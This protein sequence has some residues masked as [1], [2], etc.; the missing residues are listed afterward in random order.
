M[1]ERDEYPAGTPC[2]VD[3]SQPDPEAA[4]QFYG[5]LFGWEFED[6]MPAGAPGHYFAASLDG[7]AVAA[8]GSLPEGAPPTPFWST[9]IWVD[10][11]HETAA[12]VRAAGGKVL[13]EPFD[14]GD[15]GRMAV[16]ADRSG[17]VYCVWQAGQ[18]RG[19]QVVNEPGSWNWS[20]LYTRDPEGALA[21]YGEVFGWVGRRV[22]FGEGMEATMWC[23]PGYADHL[24]RVDPGIRERHAASG[25]PE[26]FSDAIGWLIEM[27]SDQF[28]DDVR[29]H[30]RVTF[31]V[32]DA[33]AI[34]TH[35]AELG[36]AILAPPFDAGPTRM[37]GLSD[38]Q[39][40]MFWVSHYAS[41]E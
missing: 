24:E 30:W 36:G 23:L 31:A 20:D 22:E 4:T 15:A 10:D 8:V 12:K 13:D 5:P 1:I 3:T 40:A 27:S 14:I 32:D 25:A 17:A 28:P 16:F 19:A 34:A 41:G 37:A 6:R 18:H 33:D 35:A 39:G 21:F 29:P 2:W 26:G 11:A 9:Y 7:R 38:A